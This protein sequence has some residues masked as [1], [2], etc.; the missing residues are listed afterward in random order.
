MSW[1]RLHVA[2]DGSHHVTGDG[3]PAYVE[4]FD[5]V[6]K[7]HPPGLA[8][9]L[10]GARAWHIRPD[11]TPAYPRRF[12][13]TFGFY[14]GLAAVV[15][16][17]GWHHI[18]PDGADAYGQRH[19]WCG[20]FQGGRCAV[21]EADGSYLHV[22]PHGQPVY[23]ERWRYAGD[24]R[25]GVAVVQA[26]DGRSTHIDLRGRELHGRW[27][28]DLDVFHKGYARARDEAGWTHVDMGGAP[29]YA[30]R[31]AAVEPF[32]N[33]QARVERFDGALEVVDE[34]GAAV[35]ELRPPRRSE[36]AA[37][38]GDMV[39]FW[40]TQ[41]IGVAVRLG[42]VE[43]LPCSEGEVARRCGLRVD[44]AHRILR[45]LAE[46]HLAACWGETWQ[47]TPRGAFLRADHPLTLADAALEYAGPFSRMWE[48]LPDALR[49]DTDWS[50]PD[51][52]SEVARDEQRRE[53]HHRMLRS[54]A[55]HDY[56][57]VVRALGLRGD[58]RIIDAAGGLGSLAQMV[59]AAHPSARVTVLDRPEVIE[60]GR[61]ELGSVNGLRWQAGDLFAAWGLDADVVLLSRVLHD[62]DDEAAR[63]ILAN[64][65]AALPAGG[66]LLVI[67]MLI[68]D[69]GVAGALCDLHLLMATGGRER[70][71][72]EIERLLS[73]T[74]FEL[75]AVRSVPA[76]PSVLLGVAT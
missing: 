54:Y 20:N 49:S 22:D 73:E 33:G 4:R 24:Y 69:G 32:Y 62:W 74:G 28:I 16:E 1:R 59:T 34:S 42:V 19:A 31:F 64:A 72:A 15:G 27:F 25:D 21:R 41:A 58:E 70:S 66:R 10:R 9:V 63:R 3:S 48:R 61:R 37:L 76:L 8:P 18:A 43:A 68:P 29:A 44:G 47:L 46:L 39:G 23:P 50:A 53:G 45:A 55:R 13:R 12:A 67:E 5:E 38:S 65:R 52:F 30:R 56:P 6:L 7:F 71:A 11:G 17:D 57:A 14:E 60:Q 40:R 26:A 36:F 2:P 51:V 75:T 35:V